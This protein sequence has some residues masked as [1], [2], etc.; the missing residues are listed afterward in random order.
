MR[1]VF[2]YS[3][4]IVN[5]Y[6]LTRIKHGYSPAFFICENQ[7]PWQTLKRTFKRK[8]DSISKKI[9]KLLFYLFYIL[10][11]DQ[12]VKRGL[13]N[14]LKVEDSILPDLMV[15]RINQ[16]EALEYSLQFQPELV[17][18]LGT[19][20]L[21]KRWL[22]SGLKIINVH[23]GIM[24]DYRGRFCWFWP[25]VNGQPEKLG[26]SIHRVTNVVDG[27]G[28]VKQLYAEPSR[29][30]DYSIVSIL[31]EMAKLSVEG[32]M[33]IHENP[34]VIDEPTPLQNPTKYP[35]YF[36]PGLRDFLRFLK[37]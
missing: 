24:P 35:I 27:G 31:S 25:V 8:N 33:Q 4:G 19:S 23:T 36:E 9:D 26:V 3:P 28:L 7:S 13:A 22:S 11:Y 29:L 37:Q 18:V 1:T 17:V 20:I 16:H 14:R 21:G 34:T 10:F 32:L 6:I 2:L 15:S 30:A 5:Q 12:R